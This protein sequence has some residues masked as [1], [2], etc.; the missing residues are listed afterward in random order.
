MK[1]GSVI[2]YLISIIVYLYQ[3]I[4]QIE[5]MKTLVNYFHWIYY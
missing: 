4:L 1:Y 3:L 2:F 5:S